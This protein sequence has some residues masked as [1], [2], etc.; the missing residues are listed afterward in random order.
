M[1]ESH[2]TVT[3]PGAEDLLFEASLTGERQMAIAKSL[4]EL[5][6][7]CE[8][9][10]TV[11]RVNL[12]GDFSKDATLPLNETNVYHDATVGLERVRGDGRMLFL[13]LHSHGVQLHVDER[14][15]LTGS[16]ARD[17]ANLIS[18]LEAAEWI[19]NA[20]NITW[21]YCTVGGNSSVKY[22][23]GLMDKSEQARY[24]QDLYNRV[25]VDSI[26]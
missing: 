23:S 3:Y 2:Y 25:E 17:K 14:D 13:Y 15:M 1:T 7:K 11:S 8:E 26:D 9:V 5:A 12:D 6:S 24:L 16:C 22:K 18:I 19:A 4:N 21:D 20:L 10:F